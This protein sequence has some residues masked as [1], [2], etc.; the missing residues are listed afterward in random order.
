MP[1]PPPLAGHGRT[2]FWEVADPEGV[3]V[4]RSA[5][6]VI[7]RVLEHGDTH[8]VRWALGYY[9]EECIREWFLQGRGPALLKKTREFWRVYLG[10]SREEL[11]A[12]ESFRPARFR[13]WPH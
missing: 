3:D 4:D 1:L 10:L 11:C 9:G 12:A 6:Y 5:D 7:G 2:Y 13:S 8:S